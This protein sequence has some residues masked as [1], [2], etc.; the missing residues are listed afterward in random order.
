MYYINTSCRNDRIR[1]VSCTAYTRYDKTYIKYDTRSTEDPRRSLLVPGASVSTKG[2]VRVDVHSYYY[3]SYGHV[4]AVVLILYTIICIH[5]ISR[6]IYIYR[7]IYKAVVF[8]TLSDDF[9]RI[10]FFPRTRFHGYT[11]LKKKKKRAH[12]LDTLLI[13]FVIANRL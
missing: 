5:T 13:G 6:Y 3:C 4:T 10:F 2:P 9:F 12:P 1:S 7:Y 11:L 8:P